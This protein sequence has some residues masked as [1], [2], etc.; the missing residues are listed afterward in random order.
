MSY[1]LDQGADPFATDA[2]DNLPLHL[3]TDASIAEC[4]VDWC[5]DEDNLGEESRCN[6]RSRML[7]ARNSLGQNTLQ[8]AIE[9]F[10]ADEDAS[11]EDDHED[12]ITFLQSYVELLAVSSSPELKSEPAIKLNPELTDDQRKVAEDILRM[13]VETPASNVAYHILGFLCLSDVKENEEY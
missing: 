5:D 9:R 7:F 6:V 13:V 11:L 4:I 10:R 12:I 2:R 3:A 1:L 8:T